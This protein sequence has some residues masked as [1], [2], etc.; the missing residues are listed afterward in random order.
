MGDCAPLNIQVMH[1]IHELEGKLIGV[2]RSAYQPR[3]NQV[4]S[5]A[6]CRLNVILRLVKQECFFGKFEAVSFLL[7]NST[8]DLKYGD[9]KW[10]KSPEDVKIVHY[11]IGAKVM[12]I[13]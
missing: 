4:V 8:H 1:S 6:D 10:D 7:K 12:F 3:L 5:F 13:K 11:K 2:D 9:F